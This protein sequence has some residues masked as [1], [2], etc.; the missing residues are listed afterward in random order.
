M[1]QSWQLKL[2][3]FAGGC[4][5]RVKHAAEWI[6]GGPSRVATDLKH[7][8]NRT[9]KSETFQSCIQA[10]KCLT[11]IL[12]SPCNYSIISI[13]AS[14]ILLT[15]SSGKCWICIKWLWPLVGALFKTSYQFN[16]WPWTCNCCHC[17]VHCEKSLLLLSD[18]IYCVPCVVLCCSAAL[19]LHLQWCLHWL[20]MYLSI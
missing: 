11:F 9:F 2:S 20:S 18:F 12:V 19:K 14:F 10:L 8:K 13:S 16:R 6:T 4:K 15:S 17:F 5:H 7:L 1:S 3:I